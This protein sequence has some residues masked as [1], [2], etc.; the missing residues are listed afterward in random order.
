M[1]KR[2]VGASA[3]AGAAQRAACMPS[4]DTECAICLAPYAEPE[5]LGC[6]HSF[7]RACIGKLIQHHGAPSGRMLAYALL[8]DNG[9]SRIISQ[10]TC[11]CPLCREP[12][13]MSR[14]VH[15]EQS[16]IA[17]AELE[18]ERR[19]QRAAQVLEHLNKLQA[20][21][22][23]PPV[24]RAPAS[25]RLPAFFDGAPRHSTSRRVAEP[26]LL[27]R[28]RHFLRR[29]EPR[30]SFA[31]WQIPPPPATLAS[32]AFSPSRVV[33]DVRARVDAVPSLAA[34]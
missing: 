20:I 26:S 10:R 8:C 3:A 24:V 32:P 12:F 29:P 23:L 16:D 13:P 1:Y 30:P 22:T 11:A 33:P 28:A 18:L 2:Q 9:T 17:A 15:I 19:R 31:F 5:R 7:C 4:A 34:S 27:G 6:G 21:T 25:R 14:F